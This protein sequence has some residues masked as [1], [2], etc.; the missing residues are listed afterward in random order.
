[1]Q[2]DAERVQSAVW[3]RDE[4]AEV[5]FRAVRESVWYDIVGH[6]LEERGWFDRVTGIVHCLVDPATSFFHAGE[7]SVYPRFL[8]RGMNTFL[9]CCSYERTLETASEIRIS[10]DINRTGRTNRNLM[11]AS[12]TR[13]SISSPGIEV[14]NWT[15][16]ANCV[17]L[18]RRSAT[19]S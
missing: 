10:W 1:M 7:R 15:P 3:A 18:S 8:L 11:A 12:F 5:L 6:R 17:E 19:M 4:D 2:E 14:V 13:P 16:M 9:D